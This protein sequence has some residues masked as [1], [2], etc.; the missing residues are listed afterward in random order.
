MKDIPFNNGGNNG[1]IGSPIFS[2]LRILIAASPL[3][4][5]YKLSNNHK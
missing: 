5:N 1:K 4:G 2:L 3:K